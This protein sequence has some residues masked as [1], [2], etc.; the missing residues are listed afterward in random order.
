MKAGENVNNH[1]LISFI[2]AENILEGER[3]DAGRVFRLDG[4]AV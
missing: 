4:S 3:E 2:K 1:A